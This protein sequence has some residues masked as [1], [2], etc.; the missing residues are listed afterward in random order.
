[1]IISE[2]PQWHCTNTHNYASDLLSIDG[3]CYEV[4]SSWSAVGRSMQSRASTFSLDL[5]FH[6]VLD[7]LCKCSASGG[8]EWFLLPAF[9]MFAETKAERTPTSRDHQAMQIYACNHL[10][11]TSIYVCSFVPVLAQMYCFPNI[12]ASL[13]QFYCFQICSVPLLSSR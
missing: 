11:P 5:E 6:W 8:L 12:L 10:V 1:M 2:W 7:G 9:S 13:Q 3:V 4:K